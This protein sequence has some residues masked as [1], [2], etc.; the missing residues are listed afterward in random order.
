MHRLFIETNEFSSL[1]KELNITQNQIRLLQGELLMNPVK[2]EM[3]V[4]T[5]GARKVRMAGRGRGKSGG[6]RVM[7]LDLEHVEVT[8]FIYV[9]DKDE[10]DNLTASQRSYVK[11]VIQEI[12]NQYLN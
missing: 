3:M 8:Y 9:F 4:G 2:G 1:A 5:G 6:F 10:A 12:K 7:Y 11:C